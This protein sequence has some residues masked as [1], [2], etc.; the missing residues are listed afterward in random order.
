MAKSTT[1]MPKLK[2]QYGKNQRNCRITKN[3]EKN[4]NGGSSNPM[5]DASVTAAVAAA[6]AA[7]AAAK[8]AAEA[9][10]PGDGQQGKDDLSTNIEPNSSVDLGTSSSLIDTQPF[11]GQELSLQTMN[12]GLDGK[13]KPQDKSKPVSSTPVSGT[14]WCVVWTGDNRSFFYNPTTK[15]SVWERPPELVGRV[16]VKEMLKSQSSAEK[17]KSKLQEEY[18]IP[19]QQSLILKVTMKRLGGKEVNPS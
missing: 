7:A 10:V 11:K 17:L 6:Q 14:P 12:K 1:T 3:D 19:A 9:A 15:K 4:Q 13:L 8:A 16:D 5:S 2:N 18:L